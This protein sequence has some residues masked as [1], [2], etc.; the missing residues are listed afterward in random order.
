MK[1]SEWEL[2]RL[3]YMVDR[4]IANHGARITRVKNGT[5]DKSCLAPGRDADL[6]KI[7]NWIR[8]RKEAKDQHAE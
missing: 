2:Y 4:A 3:V 6:K 1:I 8:E 7:R 5:S